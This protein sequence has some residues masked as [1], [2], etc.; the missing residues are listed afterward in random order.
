M[1]ETTPTFVV[2]LP[3]LVSDDQEAVLL[4]RL[5]AARQVYN[6]C[7]G[8]ALNRREHMRHSAL[9][10]TA[11]TL[12]AGK[13]RSELFSESRQAADFREYDLHAYAVQ[14]GKCWLGA[15]L[16]SLTIQKLA[17]RAFK[18]VENYHFGLRGRPRFKSANQVD[19][20]EGKTNEA[21][22]L[23][24]E[25]A[26]GHGKSKVYTGQKYVTWLGLRLE[27]ILDLS[28]A[29]TK[30]GLAAPVKYVRLVRRKIGS[31]NR[32]YVQ[33]VCKGT[34]YHKTKNSIGQGTVGL[35]IGPSTIA[36]VGQTEALLEQFCDQLKPRQD[37]IRRLQR[38]TDRQRRANNH[39]NYDAEGKIKSGKKTWKKSRRQ[40][41]TEQK[42]AELHRK[43]AAY[44]ASLHGNLV[45]RILGLGNDIRL[46]KLSYKAFQKR[47]GKS[48]GFR[49]P[50][51][52]VTLLKRKAASAAVSVTDFPTRTTKL[53]RTC[54][55]CGKIEAKPLSERWHRCECG[56]EAQRDLYSAFLA[57]CVEQNVLNADLAERRWSGADALLRTALSIVET[58]QANGRR[59]P[60]SFGV[61]RKQSLSSGKAM[62][63]R[64]KTLGAVAHASVVDAQREARHA[65]EPPGF[66]Y[67]EQSEWEDKV[68]KKASI[69]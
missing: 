1:P 11:R 69:S 46:E 9:Y 64:A 54:H 2:E 37:E 56:V 35:D 23:W 32:F 43:Q 47:F 29:V 5:E 30:H 12:K 58:Q 31:H 22:I 36:V 57:T 20:V 55:H 14:F 4:A 15:H 39:D 18:A 68:R 21:G 33:L 27:P 62:A 60:A 40:Q 13:K 7:L 34:P 41:K 51:S 17:S 63:Q 67:G 16:D 38:K 53:S 24:R 48:V 65:A 3:L 44:R 52:F 25:E 59:L 19:S 6:A 61:S 10:R 8:E 42:L 26:I 50:G 49:G 45:N 66:S 28:D